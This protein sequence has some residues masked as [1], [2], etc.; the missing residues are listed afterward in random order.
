MT[1][2]WLPSP[3]RRTRRTRYSGRIPTDLHSGKAHSV[4]HQGE[5]QYL[6]VSSDE[7]I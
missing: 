7:A 1:I 3:T 4:S 5:L 2:D 6:D